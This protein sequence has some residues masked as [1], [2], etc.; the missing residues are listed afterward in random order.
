MRRLAELKGNVETW[1]KVESDTATAA[2]LADLMETEGDAALTPVAQ[3]VDDLEARLAKLE[4]QLAF[5]GAHDKRNAILSVHAGAGGTES[6]D[7]AQMLL[8]M[9]LRWAERKGFATEI[10]DLTNADVAG[11]KSAMVEI[12]GHHAY[13][14][15]KGER[16]VH[17]LVRLSPFDADHAR[18][19]SFAL[20][21]LLPE[22]DEA[23]EININPD[24]LRIDYFRSG[25]AGGQNVQ[26]T[27]TAI[28][29]VHNPTNIVVSVQ[30]ERSQK[31]NRETAMKI[32]H[33]R[34]MEIE[35][36]KRAEEQARL[37][38]EHVS[39]EFGSQIRSYVL[40]PYK[41]VKDHRTGY[42]RR[43][44]NDILD[45]DLDEMIQSYLAQHVGLKA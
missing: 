9:Y 42:E 33:A 34:L 7:W 12:R 24:D 22:A 41:L 32:L 14:Y 2:E 36:E 29:I 4:F 3:D 31:Q 15:L 11:I 18:H 27:S 40:H 5:T 21:E 19:T 16:G 23:A 13:G 43:N 10:L 30:T 37:K 25:G 6:Q 35:E 38:G 26:K 45:G 8:R 17:R 44:P 20:V 1:R 28:R 39:A